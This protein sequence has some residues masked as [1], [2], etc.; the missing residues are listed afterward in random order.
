MCIVSF[1][2]QEHPKYKLIIAANRDEFYRRP[3]DPLRVW[4]DY[5]NIV[6]GRD[7]E[8]KGTWLGMSKDGKFATLTNYRHP[9]YFKDDDKRTRGDIVTNYLTSSVDPQAYLEELHER[10]HEYSGF[11]VIVGNGDELFYYSNEKGNIKE[12]ERGTHSLSNA[13]LN[14]PWPK[15]KRAKSALDHYVSHNEEIDPEKLFKQL[16]NDTIAPDEELPKT[17]LS[18]EFERQVSSI[19]IRSEDYG[20]RVS[21]VILITHDNEVKLIERTFNNGQF[22]QDTTYEFTITKSSM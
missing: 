6:A 11:N 18:L 3:A 1:N 8:A 15:V 14:T 2:F 4:P 12:I 16:H 13:F 22:K 5:P 10:R 21:T 19:F 17:G 7:L 9:K 20:T